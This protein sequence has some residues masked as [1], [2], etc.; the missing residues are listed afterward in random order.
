MAISFLR[1]PIQD[2]WDMMPIT[3]IAMID[4]YNDINKCEWT[5]IRHINSGGAIE[6][7]RDKKRKIAEGLKRYSDPFF[8]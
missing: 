2:F 6:L 1:L 5:M 7:E 4:E 8:M 3:L